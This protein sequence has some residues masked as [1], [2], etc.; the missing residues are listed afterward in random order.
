MSPG[1]CSVSRSMNCST[2]V[3]NVSRY[4]LYSPNQGSFSRSLEDDAAVAIKV[5][6]Y[7]KN[8]MEQV[9]VIHDTL[10]R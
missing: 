1:L 10:E 4:K 7:M 9:N 8:L 2:V 3:S 5:P 6:D